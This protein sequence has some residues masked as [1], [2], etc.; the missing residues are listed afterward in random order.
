MFNDLAA[1][2]VAM[3]GLIS[4][5]A[6]SLVALIA[7]ASLGGC[8]HSTAQNS[9]SEYRVPAKSIEQVLKEKSDQWMAIAG[10][11]GTA[12]GMHKGKPCV[13]IFTSVKIQEL[14]DRIPTAVEGYPV[15]I[16]YTGA[17]RKGVRSSR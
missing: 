7:L 1:Q 15:I 6:P 12:I 11:E 13:R 4:S 17:F 14:R 2:K 8:R 5:A 3:S 9:E 10:V 16:E